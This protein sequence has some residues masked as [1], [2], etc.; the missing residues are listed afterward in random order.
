MR[1][2]RRFVLDFETNLAS[3]LLGVMLVVM[4]LQVFTRYVLNDPFG[5][6]EEVLR[7]LYVFVVFLGSS[8]AISDRSHVSISFLVEKLPRNGQIAVAVANNLLIIVF[9]GFLFYWGVK[10]AESNHVIPL[11]TVDLM[12]SVVYAIVPITAVTMT[13]RTLVIMYDDVVHKHA[14]VDELPKTVI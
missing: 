8:A 1:S 10:A 3:V 9:L 4:T 5:W 12:Y 11:M 14:A 2:L 13:L 7:Y 6:T